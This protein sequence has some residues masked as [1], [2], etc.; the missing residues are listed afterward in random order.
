MITIHKEC[1]PHAFQDKT[2][3]NKRRVVNPKAGYGTGNNNVTCTVC[4]Q[5]FS[6]APE[7]KKKK[8]K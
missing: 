1:K 2:Y 7:V 3:G 4:G 6:T 5:T 8:K